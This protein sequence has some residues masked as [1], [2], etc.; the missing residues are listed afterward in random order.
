[1]AGLL[2]IHW[3]G[4]LPQNGFAQDRLSGPGLKWRAAEEYGSGDNALLSFYQRWIS[5]VKGGDLCPMHPSCS[6]YA[7]LLFQSQ[8][9][10]PAYIGACERL[11]RCGREL[12]LYKMIEIN[13]RFRWHDPPPMARRSDKNA[14]DAIAPVHLQQYTTPPPKL[15]RRP[16]VEEGFADFLFE[17]GE[18]ERASTE[19]LR[20][21]YYGAADTIRQLYYL[22]KIGNC[23][24]FGVDYEGCIK[25]IERHR[26]RFNHYPN[27]KAALELLLGKTY[28]Q[29]QRYDKAI[30]A[31]QWSGATPQQAAYDETQLML[32]LC[33]ARLYFW[34]TAAE[35]LAKVRDISPHGTLA[36][37]ISASLKKGQS[38][39]TRRPWVAGALSA[40]VP[41]AGYLYAHRPN[42]AIASFLINSLIFWTIR[43]AV[44]DK[45]YGLATTTAFFGIGW[46]FGNIKGSRNAA[47]Q[48]N[49][50]VRD[51]FLERLLENVAVEHDVP[52][53]TQTH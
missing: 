8:A 43:D 29:L 22:Q 9:G 51:R 10:L 12:Y 35:Y 19:Y 23:L 36:E 38:L 52:A 20:L 44:K 32:G 34:D 53:K 16:S 28:Y 33:Y 11:L 13:E 26:S 3:C 4:G 50:K 18:Y 37:N 40:M 27:D 21:V 45:N 25:F 2:L 41:G 46:Y 42:T 24:Y 5:P 1:M 49:A 30:T 31:L 47:R 14:F 39:P 7:K 17:N 15:E 48:F 6:Q